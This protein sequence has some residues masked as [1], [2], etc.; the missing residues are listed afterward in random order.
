MPGSLFPTTRGSVVAA[1]ASEDA[2]ERTRAFDSLTR[3]YWRP[4]FEYARVVHRRDDADDLTQA[5]L[6]IAFERDSLAAYDVQKASFRTFL[7]V[8]FDR[9]IAN[10][11]RAASRLKRG[12]DRDR[13]ELEE[14]VGGLDPEELFHREWIRSVF[15]IAIERLREVIDPT[16]FAIFEAYDV[17]AGV[18]YRD[19]AEQ[20]GVSEVTVTNRLAAARRR[21]R[22]IVIDLLR[23]VTASASEFRVEVKALLGVDL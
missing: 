10:D 18:K 7:R 20:F 12:G 5:F 13:V 22:A 14:Q 2:A 1:L 9:F 4:L 19:L 16:D 6:A 11:A 23:E 3:I 8:L 15:M 21:F 17:H